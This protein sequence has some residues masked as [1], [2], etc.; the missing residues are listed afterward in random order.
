MSGIELRLIR[1]IINLI[2]NETIQ[3]YLQNIPLLRG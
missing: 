1:T 3:S 2:L